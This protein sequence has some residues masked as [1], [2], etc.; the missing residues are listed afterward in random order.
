MVDFSRLIGRRVVEQDYGLTSLEGWLRR[1]TLA[2]PRFAEQLPLESGRPRH[3]VDLDGK[4]VHSARMKES[5]LFRAG[6]GRG[7]AQLFP[8]LVRPDLYA[9]AI[10]VRNKEP[11]IRLAHS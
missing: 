10:G 2:Y 9:R 3:V 4:V 1:T 11:D 8:R 5:F 6:F 7:V